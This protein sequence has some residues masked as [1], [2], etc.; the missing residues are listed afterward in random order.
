MKNLR[1]S[2][3]VRRLALG[4]ALALSPA[5]ASCAS[6]GIADSWVDPALA[7]FPHFEKVFVAYLGSDATSQ[8]VAE[9][10][11][12]KRL[13]ASAPSKQYVKCYELFP[14]AQEVDPA[15]IRDQL[16]AAGCDGAAILHLTRVE[17]EVS[18]SPGAYPGYYGSFGHCWGWAY[19]TPVDV[20]T[21]EI[22]HVVTN[23]YSLADDKL[24]Y[25]ARSETFN[26]GST[27]AM[28]VEIAEAIRDDLEEKG[29]LR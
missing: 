8:R 26:P 14:N 28:I 18:Y 29:L 12:A 15:A 2:R 19:S 5:L 11:L 20:R 7:E 6:T 9:D 4:L 24:V 22:V 13:Q 25:S 27:A 10:A 16:R 1:V 23:V 21:D 17:Q 3:S